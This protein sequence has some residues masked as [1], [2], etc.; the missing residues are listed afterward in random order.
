MNVTEGTLSIGDLAGPLGLAIIALAACLLGAAMLRPRWA[1]PLLVIGAIVGSGPKLKGYVVYDELFLLALVGGVLLAAAVG[2]VRE[3]LTPAPRTDTAL[4][5]TWAL[6]MAVQSVR[7]MLA[8]GDPRIARWIAMYLALAALAWVLSRYRV[9]PLRNRYAVVVGATVAVYTAYLAAGAYWEATVAPGAR[10][11]AQGYVWAGTAG[12]V[13]PTV[14]AFPA[15]LLLAERQRGWMRALGVAGLL[16]IAAVAWYY[17]SRYSWLVMG[18]YVVLWLTNRLWML[19]GTVAVAASFVL[20]TGMGLTASDAVDY[21]SDQTRTLQFEIAR[22]AIADDW[23]LA[24]IGAGVYT[25]RTILP[26]YAQRAFDRYV[27]DET[28][29]GMWL[30]YEGQPIARGFG[31]TY[32]TTGLPA[33]FIDTGIL[34]IG[35][36]AVL[37]ILRAV[38]LARSTASDRRLWLAALAF[39][40]AAMLLLN[41]IDLVLFYLL[42]MPDGL[43]D[44]LAGSSART[45]G[46]R[47]AAATVRAVRAA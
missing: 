2:V 18:G 9:A 1:W 21:V 3:R 39:G 24:A 37:F 11:F 35:L 34:G 19:A 44:E 42:I 8:E 23:T 46:R 6:L 15:A 25:H 12:A 22:D 30:D 43:L 13:F 41:P 32:R 45:A 4:F 16:V 40:G 47:A 33:F 29:N 26:P 10:F 5:V 28:L 31:G 14:V 7:G 27:S 20:V 38:A 17:D 36:L